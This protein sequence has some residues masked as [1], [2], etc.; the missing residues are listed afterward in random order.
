[1]TGQREQPPAAAAPPVVRFAPSPTGRLHIGN[2][3][4]AILNWL[5]ARR[6][7]GIFILRLDDTDR[8]RSSEAFAAAIRED[9][10]WLGLHWAREIRQSDRSARYREVADRLIERGQLYS[11]YESEEELE[12]RRKIQLSQGLPPVYDRARAEAS[13]DN[14]RWRAEGRRPYWRFRLGS[15][16]LG[17]AP[18][19]A[20][21]VAWHDLV[22]G[23]QEIDA[24]RLSDPVL[25]RA[26]GTFL[27]TF[28]SVVDDADLAVSH[29]IRGEDHVTNTAVQL[30]I[31]EA[32]AAPPPAFAHHSL[33]VDTDGRALSKRLGAL[34]VASF[35]DAGL[36]PMAVA[37]HAALVGTSDAIEAHTSLAS[38]SQG[39]DLARVSRAPARF[40]PAEL[41]ELN[42]SLLHKFDFPSV[43][44][45]LAALG[46]DGDAR[47]WQAVRGNLRTLAD[48][49]GWWHVV[50]AAI[51]PVMEAPD[52]CATACGL[53]PAEPW[54][55]ATWGEWTA[56]VRSRTG[57]KGRQLFHPLRLALTGREEG[58]E[59]RLLLPLIGRSRAVARLSG[60]RG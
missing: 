53:L 56:A 13:G 36:E 12:R 1:M 11:C 44:P 33:L 45:R 22:R 6:H 20:I 5:H 19:A 38:L 43:A 55:E 4:T 47:F 17:L 51:E 16:R 32:L 35:R 18:G 29:V 39:F 25:I 60:R 9:L 7:G 41:A 3:R 23:P 49:A 50:A 58:P 31:F 27:Y 15:G 52:L 40:D 48:A 57:A 2:I 24:A 30:S 14:A 21:P 26:D 34:S 28:T 54:N 46:I 10:G 37:S 59:L 8:E 42:A